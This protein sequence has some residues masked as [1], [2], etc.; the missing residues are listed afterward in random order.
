L[1]GVLSLTFDQIIAPDSLDIHDV[2]VKIKRPADTAF[3][4]LNVLAWT[5]GRTDTATATTV[6][7]TPPSG[8][9]L[10]KNSTYQFRLENIW[11]AS[12]LNAQRINTDFYELKTKDKFCHLDSI[13]VSPFEQTI[14][15]RNARNIP[16]SAEAQSGSCALFSIDNVYE[17][18]WR[19]WE[20]ATA[21]QH[22]LSI[23]SNSDPATATGSIENKNQNG[24]ARVTA[25]VEITVDTIFNESTETA[26]R[27]VSGDGF[28]NVY[29]CENPWVANAPLGWQNELDTRASFWY[30]RDQGRVNDPTDDLPALAAVRSSAIDFIEF[31]FPRN[32]SSTPT[33]GSS[34]AISFRVYNNPDQLSARAWYAVN[35][36][37]P[38]ASVADVKINCT[39]DDKG[40]ACYYGVQDGNTLYVS[41]GKINCSSGYVDT[42]API[43][44]N[45]LYSNIFVIGYNQNAN[46]STL[47]I[48]SQLIENFKIDQQYQKT[49]NPNFVKRDIKRLNDVSTIKNALK[50]YYAKK[51]TFPTLA[52]GS[53]ERGATW[54][55]WP[56]WQSALGNDLGVAMPLD[57]IN[58]FKT[59]A[60][61]AYAVD[62]AGSSAL[63]CLA[64]DQCFVDGPN[65]SC[66]ICKATSDLATC[67]DSTARQVGYEGSE[68]NDAENYLYRYSFDNYAHGA[69]F[70]NLEG[71]NATYYNNAVDTNVA[72]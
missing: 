49:L 30:C 12:C 31:F 28:V 21:G 36:P 65:F 72:P 52:G 40:E 32:A 25:G 63:K 66:S 18:Q 62:C 33:D 69:L 55:I 58:K 11:G 41:G 57:P 3:S 46:A 56:S 60:A 35:A 1:N 2:V 44:W 39:D 5:I 15:N 43:N 14:T 38:S 42:C 7:L 23:V 24:Q 68:V 70:Y 20:V 9:S 10:E 22:I 13:V 50:A 8:Q 47:A 61:G 27:T 64:T 37:N 51:Q 6:T 17:W 45:K 54:S 19:T 67:Y 16:F 26:P 59:Y 29:L 34:D 4:A 53:Y 48:M 71:K